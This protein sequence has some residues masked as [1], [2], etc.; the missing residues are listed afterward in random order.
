MVQVE[1]DELA[2]RDQDVV[3][4]NSRVQG[5]NA[6]G[7]FSLI[8]QFEVFT[9]TEDAESGLP[10]AVPKPAQRKCGSYTVSFGLCLVCFSV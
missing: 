3:A 6:D 4:G 5:T 10:P 8:L 7:P 1:P 2:S 9:A